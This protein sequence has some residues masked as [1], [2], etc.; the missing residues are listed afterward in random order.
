[1]ETPYYV[2]H[3]KEMEQ[4]LL[5]LNTALNKYWG[6]FII[7]YSFKT[8][9]LPWLITF[10]KSQGFF[11]EVVSN[12]E[13]KLAKKLG[14]QVDRIIYN[15]PSKSRDTYF[16]AVVQGAIVNIDSKRE[17]D[18]LNEIGYLANSKIGLRV[19]FDMENECFGETQC[20]IEDGRFGFSYEN[21]DLEKALLYLKDKKIPINGLHLH[22]SSKTRSLN[23]YSTMAKKT[24]E[25]IKKYKLQLDYID[26]G[27]GFFGGIQGQPSFEDYIKA[28]S[29]RLL[30][31]VNPKRTKLIIE[32]GMA[33]VGA[34]IDYVTTVIDVKSTVHNHFIV[35]DGSRTNIDP[36]MRKN[37]YLY[38]VH[39]INNN[40]NMK[41]KQTIC[42]FTCMEHDRLFWLTDSPE[43]MVGD[44]ITYYKVGAYTISLTPLFIQFFPAIYVKENDKYYCVRRKWTE[45]DYLA[46]NILY[47]EV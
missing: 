30:L 26:I 40:S 35:T 24:V 31:C 16:E 32:P 4:N 18:W 47:E 1:M 11:A 8:N 44:Q 41:K 25:V 46:G 3:K 12:D 14:Y 6:N 45:S 43:L 10:M 36:F 13:Y 27:G 22:C 33:V 21:G 7:G 29:E 42:G 28:I 23:I 19:N 37:S 38:N 9:S 17:L 39:Q 2:I 34:Y 20:G 15:G 5:R